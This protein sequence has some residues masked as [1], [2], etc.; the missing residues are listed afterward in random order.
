MTNLQAVPLTGIELRRKVLE[1]KLA[2]ATSRSKHSTSKAMR[3]SE[4]VAAARYAAQLAEM[5]Q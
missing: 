3:E 4:A 2:I 5:N 1:D